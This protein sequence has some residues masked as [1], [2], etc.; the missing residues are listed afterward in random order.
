MTYALHKKI[1]KMNVGPHLIPVHGV[2]FTVRKGPRKAFLRESFRCR[3]SLY[4][5]ITHFYF[6]SCF[7]QNEAYVSI[8]QEDLSILKV[9]CK[10]RKKYTLWRKI[11]KLLKEKG[12]DEA[13]KVFMEKAQL[14]ALIEEMKPLSE[15]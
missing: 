5:L 10:Y 2:H 15:L 11:L 4:K 1:Y 8:T 3:A 6:K 14:F 9:I 13:W 12:I 7:S